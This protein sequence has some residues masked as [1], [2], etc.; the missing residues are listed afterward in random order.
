MKHEL[1]E[2]ND[3]WAALRISAD[4]SEV[5]ADY[6][7][8]F[9][10]YAGLAVPGF[11]PGKAPRAVIERRF[12]KELR[13]DFTV[14]CGR[15][16]VGQALGE[17][18]LR[19]AGSISL[20]EVRFEPLGE[21]ALT[22]E[23]VPVPKL[24]LPEYAAVPLTAAT[25]DERRDELSGWLLAHTEWDVPEPLVRQEC[26]RDGA[27]EPGSAAWQAAAQRVKL[28]ETLAQIAEREGIE[29]DEQ[30]VDERIERI[31]AGSEFGPDELRRQLGDGGVNRLH[32]L[33]LAE[34]TLA[35]LLDRNPAGVGGDSGER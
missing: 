34:Q 27:T 18:G 3:G 19:A 28:M 12:R 16:L 20:V 35:Y 5:S 15:R 31:S 23:C 21:F 10:E 8:V 30:D 22:A 4:W 2:G 33:L 14:R 25:D 7:D 9:A 13:D 29:V 6:D 24:T 1:T 26:E 17:R 32:S 11:R